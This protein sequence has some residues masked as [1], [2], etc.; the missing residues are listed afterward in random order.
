MS[1]DTTYF[2]DC[3]E[4]DRL[5]AEKAELLAALE[6]CKLWLACFAQGQGGKVRE[7]VVASERFAVY[8]A[9][10]KRAKEAK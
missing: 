2:N 8:L 9:A 10:I 5:R 1:K 7:E 6:D 3:E 4:I